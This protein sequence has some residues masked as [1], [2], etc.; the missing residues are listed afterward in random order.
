M[1]ENYLPNATFGHWSP[2]LLIC[3]FLLIHFSSFVEDLFKPL[4][5]HFA[6]NNTLSNLLSLYPSVSLTREML[7]M[8]IVRLPL[9][10]F[11]RL[12]YFIDVSLFF[13][14]L[15]SASSPCCSRLNDMATLLRILADRFA[16]LSRTTRPTCAHFDDDDIF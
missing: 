4:D 11:P 16:I 6:R 2:D 12:I 10:F 1:T 5:L 8:M 9:P 7:R 14:F 13:V 3:L 15:F